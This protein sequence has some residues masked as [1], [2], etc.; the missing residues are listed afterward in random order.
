MIGE[1]AKR[2]P[3][4][5]LE[6]QPQ[7][8]WKKVKGFRDFLAHNYEAVIL[9]IVWG[10]VEELPELRAA[11]EKLLMTAQVNEADEDVEE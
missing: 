5:L 1:I 7:V 4:R 6:Q 10:A 8:A 3:D 2:L 9:Q 11:V